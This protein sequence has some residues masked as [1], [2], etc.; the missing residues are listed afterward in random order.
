MP[1]LSLSKWL[2]IPACP[3]SPRGFLEGVR[4]RVSGVSNIISILMADKNGRS[5]F[6]IIC[7]VPAINKTLASVERKR[8]SRSW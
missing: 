6:T 2:A 7:I 8:F 3:P 5:S 1:A 4:C